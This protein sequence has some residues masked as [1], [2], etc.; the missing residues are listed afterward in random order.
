M[1]KMIDVLEQSFVQNFAT[2]LF[3]NSDQLDQQFNQDL[4]NVAD[5]DLE[6]LISDFFLTDN[7]MEVAQALDI[8]PETVQALQNGA[9]L[10]DQAY[11]SATAKIIAYCLA[12][13]TN[14]LHQVEVSDTLKDFH[15]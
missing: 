3:S 6:N 1:L 15:I 14:A 11:M 13:E 8:V 10:K 9:N 4:L 2:S 5:I 12:V 7:A